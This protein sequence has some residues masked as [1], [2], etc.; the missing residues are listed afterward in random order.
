VGGF[1]VGEPLVEFTDAGLKEEL[2]R[3]MA[4]TAKGRYFALADAAELP[5]AVEAAVRAARLAGVKPHDQEIWDA[6]FLFLLLLGIMGSEWFIRR[7]SG[8]A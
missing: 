1:L 6:P 2:L 4:A 3:Q 5:K 8:L 7:R